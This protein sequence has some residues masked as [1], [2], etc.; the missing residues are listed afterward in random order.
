NLATI[1][2]TSG[3]LG[4][5][6]NGSTFNVVATVTDAAGNAT[7]DVT[8]NELRVITT[9]PTAPTVNALLTNSTTPTITGLA[10]LAAGQ[11]LAVVVNGAAYAVVPTGGTWSLNL[12]TAIPPGSATPAA[13]LVAGTYNVTATITDAA[14][15][16][17]SDTTTGELVIDITAPT[18]TAV[19]SPTADGSYRATQTITI[20]VQLSKS[21]I[22][23]TTLGSPTLALNS[24][25]NATFVN[26]VGNVLNF[27]YSVQNG[28]TAAD[29]NATA[30][31]L[32]GATIKDS[33]GNTLTLTLPV[34]QATGSLDLNKAIVIDTTAPAAP[35]VTALTT[36]VT[37]PTITGSIGAATL[38]TGETLTVVVNGATYTNVP[39]TAGVGGA[40]G[41]WS[42]NLAT[43]APTSGTLGA[44]A[45]G[46]TFNVVATVTDAAG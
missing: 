20:Q 15:N 17:A 26:A 31:T 18:V 3:T 5:F 1:A 13:A 6:A 24:G 38:A 32:N 10:N 12:A 42:L 25:R 9:I 22:V 4:A 45:N 44:F 14:G 29:L 40:N 16:A 39:V 7:S 8:T 11:T 43:I 35:V 46:S 19:T 36:N 33:A 41:T 28:D 37:P 2:P 23:D 21:V 30:L 27:T 34:S